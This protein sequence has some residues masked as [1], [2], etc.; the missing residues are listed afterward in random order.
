MQVAHGPHRS[1]EKHFQAVNKEEQSYKYIS[2]LVKSSY[3]CPLEKVLAIEII[4]VVLEKRKFKLFAILLLSSFTET[5]LNSI[6]P[7]LIEIGP[8]IMKK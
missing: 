4:P 1:H 8:L 6:H 3:D 2:R 7:S 5:N